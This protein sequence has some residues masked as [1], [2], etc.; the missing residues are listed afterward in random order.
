MPDNDSQYWPAWAAVVL[1]KEMIMTPSALRQLLYLFLVGALVSLPMAAHSA[2]GA[3]LPTSGDNLPDPALAGSRTTGGDSGACGAEYV[4]RALDSGSRGTVADTADTMPRHALALP[5]LSTAPQVLLGSSDSGEAF[6]YPPWE[7]NHDCQ[8][9]WHELAGWANCTAD[10]DDQCGALGCSAS[11]VGLGKGTSQAWFYHTGAGLVNEDSR[12]DFT[13]YYAIDWSYLCHVFIVPPSDAL[14]KDDIRITFT[15]LVMTPEPSEYEKQIVLDE[16]I[17]RQDESL[18]YSDNIEVSFHDIPIPAGTDVYLSVRVDV[19][20]HAA[21][22]GASYSDANAQLVGCLNQIKIE[23]DEDQQGD[24]QAL[25]IWA[26]EDSEDWEGDCRVNKIESGTPVY[27]FFKYRWTGDV[28]CP[29]HNVEIRMDGGTFCEGPIED[30][31]ANH[32]CVVRCGPHSE[33]VQALPLTNSVS[34]EFCGITDVDND[35][36]ESSE[37]NNEICTAVTWPKAFYAVKDLGAFGAVTQQHQQYALNN[38]GQ[39]VGWAQQSGGPYPYSGHAYLWLPKAAYGLPGGLNDLGALADGWWSRAY[40][41]NDFG[42]IAGDSNIQSLATPVHA[43]RWWED[44]I[45]DLSTQGYFAY[46]RGVN[47]L[48]QVVGYSGDSEAFHAFVWDSFTETMEDL[49]TLGGNESCAYAINDAGQIVGQA[50]AADGTS[51]AALWG[52]DDGTSS[53]AVSDLGAG[54]ANDI[55]SSGEVAGYAAVMGGQSEAVIWQLAQAGRATAYHQRVLGTLG[56]AESRSLAINASGTTVGWA[57]T[58]S[59]A[60]HAFIQKGCQMLDLNNMIPQGSRWELFAATDINDAGQIVG[61]GEFDGVPRAFLL[62]PNPRRML[63]GP[64][65]RQPL[66]QQAAETAETPAPVE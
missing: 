3:L 10:S 41:I 6:M 46:G 32:A 9:V 37:N 7:H 30:L 66:Q 33:D 34:R 12:F 49:G 23:W 43:F 21:A 54:V 19:F 63:P 47:N 39:V 42:Q 36:A 51:R 60:R 28:T 61:Y 65:P 16:A 25:D 40:D 45:I 56:G 4:F 48:G 5:P 8:V 27:V 57:D 1:K 44:T 15:V 62:K 18:G 53:W 50:D 59:G 29:T 14:A 13:F 31:P 55:S 26:S 17:R 58:G 24:L 38:L 52:Y 64:V 22:G 11:A 35:V 2:D 20:V